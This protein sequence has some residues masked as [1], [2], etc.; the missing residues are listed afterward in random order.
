[1][2]RFLVFAGEHRQAEAWA[3][4]CRLAPEEWR[5]LHGPR[6]LMGLSRPTIVL[7]G[8]FYDR[9]DAGMMIDLARNRGAIFLRPDE[10]IA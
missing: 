5:A 10:A 4:K 8:T 2:I 3:R 1:M 9:T 6:D 7:V